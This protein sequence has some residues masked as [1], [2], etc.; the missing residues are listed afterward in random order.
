MKIVFHANQLSLRGT[1]VALYDYAYFNELLLGNESIIVYQRNNANNHPEVMRKFETRFP[2][3]AYGEFAEVDDVIREYN[4][5]LMYCIKSGTRDGILSKR[6]PTMVHAVFPTR[7]SEFHG[8]SFA[9]VS[10]WLSLICSNGRAPAVPHILQL[11]HISGNLR[12]E[13]RIPASATVF[14][15]YG[16]ADSFDIAFVKEVI[17]EVL[18]RRRDVYF[19]F[20][21]IRKFIDSDKVLFLPPTTD[22]AFKVRFINTADAMLHAR[23]RGE[24]FGLSCGEFSMKN[25]PIFTYGKSPERNHLYVL[26]RKAMVYSGPRSLMRLLLTF[27]RGDAGKKS[28]DCYSGKFAPETVMR[29]FDQHLI[30]KALSNGM[31]TSPGIHLDGR[32]KALCRVEKMKLRLI[33]WSRRLA[34]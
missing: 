17:P 21:N 31:V 27:D 11:P 16:G 6:V 9:F 2:T 24:S 20:L 10:E 30:Q 13:L 26:G 1:E 12:E 7:E 32:D 4:A 22:V 3:H 14:A 34:L 28:W 5:A 18:A 8:A 33:K 29:L 15:C 19:V 23:R 25:K